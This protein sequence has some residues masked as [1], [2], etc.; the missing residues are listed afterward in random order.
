MKKEFEQEETEDL[1]IEL[2][3]INR[4]GGNVVKENRKK[5]KPEQDVEAVS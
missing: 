2:I 5:E 1:G 3:D 4:Y